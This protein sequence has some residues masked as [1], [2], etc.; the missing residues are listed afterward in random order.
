MNHVC[1]R[2]LYIVV[3]LHSTFPLRLPPHFINPNVLWSIREVF[4]WFGGKF[5]AK[6]LAVLGSQLSVFYGILW[7]M[8]LYKSA[9]D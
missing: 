8:F 6:I 4:E 1:L 9:L 3:V 7:L 5:S 2:L